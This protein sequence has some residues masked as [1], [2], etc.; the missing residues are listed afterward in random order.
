MNYRIYQNI[1][2]WE[3]LTTT[4]D[5]HLKEVVSHIKGDNYILIIKHYIEL[6]QDEVHYRGIA[7]DYPSKQKVLRR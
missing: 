2:G 5:K 4:N 1:T 7:R 6:D 3:Y